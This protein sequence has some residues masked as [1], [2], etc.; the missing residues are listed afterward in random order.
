M[1]ASMQ[2]TGFAGVCR[3]SARPHEGSQELVESPTRFRFDVPHRLALVFYHRAESP[4]M[5]F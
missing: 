2:S 1:N 4:A 5:H 3:E